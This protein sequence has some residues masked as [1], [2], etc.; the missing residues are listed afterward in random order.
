MT[1]PGWRKETSGVSGSELRDATKTSSRTEDENSVGVIGGQ[2]GPDTPSSE[3]DRSLW[4]KKE[5]IRVS[6][7]RSTDTLRPS[8]KIITSL[9][10]G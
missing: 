5:M 6:I 2:V 8:T 7:E 4:R 10:P 1:P 3:S 9:I